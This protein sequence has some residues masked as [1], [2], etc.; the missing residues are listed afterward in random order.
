MVELMR[1]LKEGKIDIQKSPKSPEALA[2]LILLIEDKTISGKIAK[3]VFSEMFTSKKTPKDII[4]EKGLVQIT[5]PKEI[6][7]VIDDIIKKNPKE[8]TDFRAGKEKLLKFFVGQVMK[9]TKG[10]AN[11][12]LVNELLEKKLKAG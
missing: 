8:V 11:P 4:K 1:E 6:E 9:E 7:A 12:Q 3:T 10:K 5:D 2:E